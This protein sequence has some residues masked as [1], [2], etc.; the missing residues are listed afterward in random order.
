MVS[1]A[2]SPVRILGDSHEAFFIDPTPRTWNPAQR[3]STVPAAR[4]CWPVPGRAIPA[5]TGGEHRPG[6]LASG[7]VPPAAE[8]SRLFVGGAGRVARRPRRRTRRPDRAGVEPTAVRRGVRAGV[9]ERLVH[10]RSAAGC[11]FAR[12]ARP[13]G[14]VLRREPEYRSEATARQSAPPLDH[15]RLSPEPTASRNAGAG[16]SRSSL[17][18]RDRSR[19]R[20]G[21]RERRTDLEQCLARAAGARVGVPL[22][23]SGR[24]IIKARPRSAGTGARTAR[25]RPA[26]RGRSASARAAVSPA[27]GRAADRRSGAGGS[28]SRRRRGS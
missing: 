17:S 15:P 22:R 9:R 3:L 27:T 10:R 6:Q 14:K 5:G 2:G 8:R 28:R 26:R 25:S 11:R 16:Q 18:I 7:L 24:G 20:I 13:T 23:R 1:R 21:I 4:S 19:P 12:A